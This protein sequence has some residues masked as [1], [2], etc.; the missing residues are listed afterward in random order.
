MRKLLVYK[1]LETL[2]KKKKVFHR[3]IEMIDR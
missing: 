1:D 3:R 2:L